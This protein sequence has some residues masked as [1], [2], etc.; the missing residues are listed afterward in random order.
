MELSIFDISVFFAFFVLVVGF[1]MY[2]SRREKSSED[3]FLAGRGLTW[4]LIGFSIVAANLSTEQFVGMA[5]QGA[6]G[7]G[8]AVSAWQLLGAVG[9][10]II[11]FTLLP[12]FLRAGIYTMPEYLEYRYNAPARAIMAVYTVAIYVTVTITAVL[13]SGGLT[14]S[15]I[16]D[17][18]LTV[19]VW[20]V[21]GIAA[22]YTVWGGL[23]AV[24]WAD[25]FQG[26]GLLIGGLATAFLVFR[27]SG[28]AGE[29]FK[30]HADQLHMVLPADHPTLPWTGI[31]LGM[32]IPIVYY[33]GLN[34][35]IVQRTLAAKSLRQGQLGIIFAA[36]L[37][38]IVPFAIVIPG[39]AAKQL[40]KPELAAEADKC[41]API[42][43]EFERL[44]ASSD[45]PA[46]A[47][48]FKMDAQWQARHPKKAAEL[49]AY[50]ASVNARVRSDGEEVIEK[51]LVGY[52][53]DAAYPVLIRKL[54]SPGIRGLMFAAI[55]GAVISSLASML[56]S[57]STIFTMDLYRRHLRPDATQRRLVTL[58][59]ITTLL[60]VIIGCLLAPALGH[61]RFKGVFNFIQEFQ[62]YISPG[63]VAAFLVG[64]VVPRAPRWCGAVALLGSAPVYGLLHVLCGG[65]E[66]SAI[67]LHF[68]IRM[69]ITFCTVTLITIGMTVVAPL[70]EPRVMPVRESLDT[71]PSRLALVL[72]GVVIVGV[73]SFFIVFW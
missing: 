14:L 30:Q 22:L 61:P 46:G 49:T 7:V 44:Q 37:W 41:N 4:P 40:Y 11:A 19:A 50:N 38:L 6:G 45:P 58:G 8:L 1:S 63:I 16:F 21:G 51:N 36:G 48:V 55:A 43:A 31:L 17:L 27:A 73:I 23:K 20:I 53:Y 68:L 52:R 32:W 34:Q 9:I 2:K 10:V 5:G 28:G 39:I 47:T 29:F 54:I 59:R 15:A 62:G 26:A 13:Y 35:F 71:T 18:D 66:H 65:G 42:L 60:F 69:M 25:L 57:A 33:C 72:G 67:E 56:N 64:F 12:R 70:S 3:Y 24:A